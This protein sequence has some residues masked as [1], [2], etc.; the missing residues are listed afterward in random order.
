MYVQ[1]L[2]V[3]NNMHLCL[4]LKLQ[5]FHIGCCTSELHG[6][7]LAVPRTEAGQAGAGHAHVRPVL[8]PR[9]QRRRQR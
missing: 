7:L 1:T 6:A 9:H 4:I 3:N 8:H 2:M 5:P